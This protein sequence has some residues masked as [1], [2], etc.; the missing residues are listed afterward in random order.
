MSFAIVVDT[1]A[2][3]TPEE[4]R[5]LS[6]T[7]V[8][9]SIEVGGEVLKDQAEMSSEEFYER[10]SAS[11]TLPKSGQPSPLDFKDA[12]QAQADNGHD[13]VI[14]LHIAPALSGTISS[15]EMGAERVEVAV[16]VI[17]SCTAA[18]GLGLLTLMAAHMRDEGRTVQETVDAVNAAKMHDH[19]FVACDSLDNLLAGGR[20]TADQVESLNVLNIKPVFMIDTDGML[21]VIDKAKGMNGVLKK[22][23]EKV[24]ELT[25]QEGTQV[26][27]FTHTNNPAAVEK[28]KA[29]LASEG[30]EYVDGGT[31][32]CGATVAT[33]LGLGAVGVAALPQKLYV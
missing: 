12:F 2:D 28:L 24:K 30:V 23:V 13:A 8:P 21:K 33:H 6:V 25:E 14:S 9:L 10:M 15:S 20:M 1:T 3:L 17:D 18:A 11:E 5:D 22:F 29:L 7:Y 27:R 26:L 4:Y 32:L 19:F 16:S 31:C